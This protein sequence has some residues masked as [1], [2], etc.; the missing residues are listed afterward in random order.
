MHSFSIYFYVKVENYEDDNNLMI[1]QMF[2]HTT[3]AQS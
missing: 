2:A 3:K 1:H